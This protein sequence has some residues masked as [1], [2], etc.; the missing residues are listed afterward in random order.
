MK[1]KKIEKIENADVYNM[2]VKN[3]HNFAVNGGFIVH[4]CD[5]LRYFCAGRPYPPKMKVPKV[6]RESIFKS[7]NNTRSDLDI[8]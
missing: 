5:A 4:N 7:Q 3:H 8:W 6:P 2:Y 1:V